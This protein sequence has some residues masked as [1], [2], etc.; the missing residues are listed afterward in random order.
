M[1]SAAI[2]AV[3]NLI[4]LL[5]AS[6]QILVQ[7]MIADYHFVIFL[8]RRW[9]SSENSCLNNWLCCSNSWLAVLNL[10]VSGRRCF[11]LQT[12]LRYFDIVINV[13]GAAAAR[14]YDKRF[15]LLVV[16]KSCRSGSSFSIRL[17]CLDG[18]S[19]SQN[20]VFS[21][22]GSSG[23]MQN[24]LIR[25]GALVVLLYRGFLHRRCLN[26]NISIDLVDVLL[27]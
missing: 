25:L 27:G 11:R 8:Q 12:R 21:H 19:Y 16:P 17:L 6:V 4:F 18:F 20:A 10:F 23:A 24:I 9:L 7:Q 5:L 22:L 26:I 2:I 13:D 14:G 15:V 3:T 1:I